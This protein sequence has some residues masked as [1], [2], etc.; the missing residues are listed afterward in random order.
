[1]TDKK[2]TVCRKCGRDYSSMSEGFYWDSSRVLWRRPCKKCI[3][4]Y[5]KRPDQYAMKL[6]RNLRYKKTVKGREADRRA[7]LKYIRRKRNGEV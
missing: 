7:K 6:A 4:D 5:N 2:D 1:M 3:S